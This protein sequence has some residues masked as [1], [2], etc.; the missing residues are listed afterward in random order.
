MTE[1]KRGWKE[2]EERLL[3]AYHDLAVSPAGK[4]VLEDLRR[5]CC[6]ETTTVLMDKEGRIDPLAMAVS[7]GRRQVLGHIESSAREGGVLGAPRETPQFAQ[8]T[9]GEE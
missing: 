3:T 5:F 2:Q 6:A 8:S 4:I 7:E 1:A 9:L